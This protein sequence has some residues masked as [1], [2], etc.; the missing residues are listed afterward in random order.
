MN[1]SAPSAL[2]RRRRT[3]RAPGPRRQR[4]RA[5]VAG[6]RGH[7]PVG[8]EAAEVVD[9]R[10]VEQLDRAPKPLDPPAVAAPPQR[11]P[12]VDRV[13][14]AAGPSA[15]NASGGTPATTPSRN[16]S[17]CARW[18]SRPGRDVDRHVADQPHAALAR[19]TRAARSTRA[20]SAPGRDSIRAG[21]PASAI[22]NAWRSRNA[23]APRRATAASGSAEEPAPRRERRARLVRRAIAVGRPERQHLPPRLPGRGQ[24]VDER[25]APSGPRRPPGSDVRCSCT[26]LDR[27]EHLRSVGLTFVG[28]FGKSR[29]TC[30]LAP[31]RNQPPAPDHSIAASPRAASI[32]GGRYAGQAHASATR[33]DRRRARRSSPTATT[34]CARSCKSKAPGGRAGTSRRCT[35]IDEHVDGDTWE[36]PSPS[37]RS[38]AGSGRS[39]RGST[40]SP[41]GAR[42][43]A[44]RSTA[45]STTSPA[46]SARASCCSQAARS[47]RRARDRSSIEHAL[48]RADRRRAPTRPSTTPRSAPSSP[49]RSTATRTAR[50]A[51]GAGGAARRRRRPRARALRLLVR[52]LPALVGRLP[53][54]RARRPADR[55]AGLRRPLPHADPPDRRDQPQGPQQRADRRPGRPRQPVGDR[56]RGGRPRGGRTPSSARSTTS[57]TS[58][59]PPTSTAWTIALDFAI[60]CSRRPPV[61][62]PSTPSGSTAAPTAR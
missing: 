34:C 6:A 39:R 36:G 35:H 48:A 27:R 43:C 15:V 12:V 11:R 28:V 33:V 30:P 44:A 10:D 54:R 7:R 8:D 20:R 25:A 59:R 50:E 24:P 2:A 47:A 29:R 55:R 53:G 46:S 14:P 62:R 58:S 22:Q 32:D 37:T 19:R 42:S 4:P 23:R 17:G 40:A 45:A 5:R 57:T 61:A 9:P 31:K 18:S 49:P 52:A 3:A 13:A 16:S 56:P 26:P 1:G 60:Q 51:D 21:E 41:P 38:A